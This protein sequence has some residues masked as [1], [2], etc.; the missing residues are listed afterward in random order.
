[1][2]DRVFSLPTL[3][4]FSIKP[5]IQKPCGTWPVTEGSG[6]KCHCEKGQHLSKRFNLTTIKRIVLEHTS[7]G[8]LHYRIKMLHSQKR[9]KEKRNKL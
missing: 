8:T 2:G 4:E 3:S 5:F 7:A 1:M 6:C 9:R